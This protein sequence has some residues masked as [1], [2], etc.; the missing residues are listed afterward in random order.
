MLLTFVDEALV[1]HVVDG[2]F[3]E[4][5]RLKIYW[6]LRVVCKILCHLIV[7]KGF[8]LV[9]VAVLKHKFATFV[10]RFKNHTIIGFELFQCAF[11]SLC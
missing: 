4:C 1:S 7:Y 6:G 5:S 9:V 2:A 3:D 10:S 11:F 8:E